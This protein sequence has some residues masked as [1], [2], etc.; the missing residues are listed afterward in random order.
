MNLK[1]KYHGL[2]LIMIPF[3]Y[4]GC[5]GENEILLK[6]KVE[7]TGGV[8]RA[9][10]YVEVSLPQRSMY[11]K[12]MKMYVYPPNNKEVICTQIMEP[13]S[14]EHK[15]RSKVKLVFPVS[16]KANE[17]KVFIIRTASSAYPEVH[18]DLNI[19]GE[20]VNL[21]VE[22]KYFS[23]SFE[24]YQG[25]KGDTL[26]AGHLGSILIKGEDEV[27]LQ[28]NHPN[29]KIHWAPNFAKEQLEYKTMAHMTNPDS[30]FISSKGPFCFSFSRS[31]C[32]DGYEKIDLKGTYKLYAG[33]PYFIFSSE[34]YFKER[35]TLNLLRNDE[36]TMDSLFTHVVYSKTKD[37]YLELP[38]YKEETMSYLEQ[39]PIPDDTPWLFFYNKTKTYGFGVI[40]LLYDNRNT[41]GG[42]APTQNRHTKIT[43]SRHSGR[44]WNRRLIDSRNTVVPAGS[45]YR[46]KNAYIVFKVGDNIPTKTI[47]YY[48]K[49]LNNPL[50][51]SILN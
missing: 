1:K 45:R 9:L 6:V 21:V 34:V 50:E 43:A 22:N 28:R 15:G 7:E 10:E 14:S 37:E 26:G 30:I 5:P 44:Y 39:Y 3:L 49:C 42:D 8:D 25:Y 12:G 41:S 2:W 32:V 35:D 27:R 18:S 11:V 24:K 23:A 4:Y 47:A 29:L 19:K 48:S 31:G 17:T 40:R 16:I 33:L 13:P 46:E 20:G 51:V 36:M 38:L